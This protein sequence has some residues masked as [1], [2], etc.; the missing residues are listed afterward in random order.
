MLGADEDKE[1]T[2]F[3]LER[4]LRRANEEWVRA[5]A[6]RDG[7]TLRQMIADEF[8]LAYPF[9]GDDKDQF[10]SN[11]INGEVRVES[12]EP[13]SATIRVSGGSVW[14]LVLKLRI[15]IIGIEISP[16]PTDSYAFTQGN[17]ADGKLSC[18]ISARHITK[19]ASCT[20]SC[21]ASASRLSSFRLSLR[22]T[23]PTGAQSPCCELNSASP[24]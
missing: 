24:K 23:S 2:N 5:L 13:H 6:Q 16:A 7:T 9:E 3:E 19:T 22:L 14:F 4:E 1:P 12:L 8:E 11:V 20:A 18:C 15:G 10:V 21:A 17:T